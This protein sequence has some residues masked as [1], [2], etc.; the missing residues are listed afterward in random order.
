MKELKFKKLDYS[1]KNEE[2][3]ETIMK[4]EGILPTRATAGDAGLDLYST[5][6]TQELDNSGKLTLVYHTDIAVDMLKEYNVPI[7]TEFDTGH[8][9]PM[10]PIINGAIAHIVS[11]NEEQ[12]IEYELK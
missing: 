8:V 11:N 6:I 7:I 10:I 2:G 5:R 3:V 1:V 4:S 9:P 12:F